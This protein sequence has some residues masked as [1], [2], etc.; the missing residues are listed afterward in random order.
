VT[1]KT[2]RTRKVY[3]NDP[4][5]EAICELR[6]RQPQGV[7]PLMPGQLY[8]RLKTHFPAPPSQ[9]PLTAFA[10]PDA[11]PGLQVVMGQ[12]IP[13]QVRLSNNEDNS[14]LII[15]DGLLVISSARPYLKWEKFSAKIGEVLNAL[16]DISDGVFD[17]ERIGVRYV[18]RMDVP[19]D[20]LGRYFDIQP[21]HISMDSLSPRTFIAR[22]ELTVD[23]DDNRLVIA[24]FASVMAED[25]PSGFILDIDCIAQNQSDL[26]T[27]NR[28]VGEIEALHR[29]EKEI[30]EASVKDDA[31][32]ELFGGFE[33]GD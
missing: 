20:S 31:R 22:S 1:T 24:T 26:T 33:E 15:G 3:K 12:G 29:L 23:G 13:G 19:M 25:K 30:F 5:L 11:P 32:I 27:I 9:M 8:E 7:W 10:P 4:I 18:N 28:T 2:T 16:Y 14:V 17:I 21:L 6:F